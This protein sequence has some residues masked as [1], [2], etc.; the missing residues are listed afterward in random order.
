MPWEARRR[1]AD[2]MELELT[3]LWN[4]WYGGWEANSGPPGKQEV[5]LISEPFLP[6]CYKRRK[7]FPYLYVFICVCCG[8]DTHTHTHTRAHSYACMCKPEEGTWCSFSF[9]PTPLSQGL[10]LKQQEKACIF[11]ASGSSHAEPGI[12]IFSAR[13]ENRKS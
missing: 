5:P 11:S 9:S 13:L 12:C 10:L 3:Q 4:P 7:I 2:L 1:G 8:E 6:M